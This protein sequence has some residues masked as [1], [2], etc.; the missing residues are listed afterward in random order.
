MVKFILV[1]AS[2][3]MN[4][5]MV[6]QILDARKAD[7]QYVDIGDYKG[8]ITGEAKEVIEKYNLKQAPDGKY[9]IPYLI[10]IEDG[11]VR[12]GAGAVQFASHEVPK[13]SL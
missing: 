10:R 11:K 8:E 1:G 3:C 4:C 2:S 13:P 9:V 7:Y 12:N 6:K 5:T